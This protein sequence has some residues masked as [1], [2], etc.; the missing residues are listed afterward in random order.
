MEMQNFSV[1]KSFNVV[2]KVLIQAM[3]CP[4]RNRGY[5][6]ISLSSLN[7][8]FRGAGAEVGRIGLLNDNFLWNTVTLHSLHCI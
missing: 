1:K 4:F 5:I 2:L 3:R 8:I 6:D 7:F